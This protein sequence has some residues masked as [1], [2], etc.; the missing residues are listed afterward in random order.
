M[1][2]SDAEL[3]QYRSPPSAL[4]PSV[5][6]WPRWLSPCAERTSVRIIRWEKSRFST[7][8][9]RSIGLVKLGQPLPLSNLSTD[10]NNGSPETTSTYMPGSWLSQYSPVNGRSVP[11]FWVTWYCSGD[12]ALTAAGFLL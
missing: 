10:A 7:T 11:F 5:N 12:R 8:L 4:G 1:N 9:S 2:L 3:M 6:T